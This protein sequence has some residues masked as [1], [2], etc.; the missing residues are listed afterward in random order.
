MHILLRTAHVNLLFSLQAVA[1]YDLVLGHSFMDTHARPSNCTVAGFLFS[2]SS[3]TYFSWQSDKTKTLSCLLSLL[4]ALLLYP[5][6]LFR[7]AS[8]L[9]LKGPS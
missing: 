8:H 3:W 9:I 1:C 4:S 7:P 6:I 5:L 2:V